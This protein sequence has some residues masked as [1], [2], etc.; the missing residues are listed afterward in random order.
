MIARSLATVGLAAR[1][2]GSMAMPHAVILLYHRVAEPP[3]DPWSLA[4]AP[5]HFAEQLELIRRHFRPMSL[6][7]LTAALAAGRL[8]RRSVAVT[9]DDGYADNLLVARPLLE[10]YDVP[11]TV[12]VPSGA[13]APGRELWWDELDRLLLQPGELPRR[14]ELV[15]SDR[16]QCWELGASAHYTAEDAAR[17][18]GWRAAHVPPGPRQ[19]LYRELWALLHPLPSAKRDWVMDELRQWAGASPAGRESHRAMMP[20]ELVALARGHLVEIGAHSVTHPSLGALSPDEQWAEIVGGKE[21]LE[22]LLGKPICSFAYPYGKVHDF[23]PTTKMLVR[24]AGFRLACTNMGGVVDRSGDLYAL[25]RRYVH[26]WGGDELERRLV[27]WLT[28]LR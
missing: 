14:L 12:F 15:I 4:V 1:R 28:G 17:H 24:E 2:L 20:D 3:T 26:C 23:S 7:G 21:A 27:N 5:R 16:P 11:A 19:Q 25:P 6:R 8:P 13:P 18:Q 22:G 9:F 10:R